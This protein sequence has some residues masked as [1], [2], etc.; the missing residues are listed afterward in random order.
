MLDWLHSTLYTFY[1]KTRRIINIY[2]EWP[3]RSGEHRL[4]MDTVGTYW[5][6]KIYYPREWCG[7]KESNTF[8]RSGG[9]SPH[10]KLYHRPLPMRICV[11]GTEGFLL[12]RIDNLYPRPSRTKARMLRSCCVVRRKTSWCRALHCLRHSSV[13]TRFAD[14]WISGDP[15]QTW[16]YLTDTSQIQG[17]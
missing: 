4:H 16:Q 11:S 15:V 7:Y 14:M 8:D 1:S 5:Y 10:F 13:K 12:F 3:I 9:Y 6:P 17:Q 2:G